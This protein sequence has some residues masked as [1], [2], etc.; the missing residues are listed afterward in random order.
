M[1]EPPIGTIT[2]R[3]NEVHNAFNLEMVRELTGGISQ[4]DDQENIRF[5]FFTSSGRNFSA[6]ADLKWMREGQKQTTERL[7]SES[8]ELARLY[9]LLD[10]TG[11]ITVSCIRGRVM[12][13]AMGIVALSD[14]VLAEESALFG[15]PEV[16]LGLIPA[17]I[18]P[19]V[20]KKA[21]RGAVTE[22]MVTGR[23]F[24]VQEARRIGLVHRICR[25]GGLEDAKED[26]IRELKENGPEAMKGAK[27]LLDRLEKVPEDDFADFTSELIA[28]FRTSEEG[29]EGMNAFIE[30]RKPGWNE[31]Q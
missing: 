16:K 14:I 19:Y 30:K 26:L 25:E 9:Y 15:F 28:Q 18:A 23:I 3:R 8:L 21:V 13:G 10:K 22:L 29:Q 1:T 24:D 4:L 27:R 31:K 12:G 7:K 6:G 17:T 2:F 11:L 5:L 20:L